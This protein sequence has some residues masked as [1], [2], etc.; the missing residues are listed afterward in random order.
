MIGR[1]NIIKVIIVL[2]MIFVMKLSPL[3][4]VV[5]CYAEESSGFENWIKTDYNAQNGLPTGEA[6]TILQTQDGFIWIGSYGGLVRYDGKNFKNFSMQKDALE[7]SSIR[8]LYEGSDGTLYIGTN[9]MGVYLY[10]DG[11]FTQASYAGEGDDFYSVRSFTEASDGTIYAGTTSGL[12]RLQE[13]DGRVML[14]AVSGTGG[15]IIYDLGCDRNNVLWACSDNGR[16]ILVRDDKLLAET[17]ASLWMKDNCYSV[18]I[19][20]DGFIYLGSSKNEVVRLQMKEDN[21]E[22]ASFSSVCISTASLHTVNNMYEDAEGNIWVLADNGIG[23]IRSGQMDRDGADTTLELPSVMQ[24]MYSVCSMIEDY[25]GNLWTASTKSGVTYFSHG[26]FTNFNKA[27]GLENVAINAIEQY[28]GY[29]YI[30]TDYGLV[31]LNRDC[32]PVVNALTVEL[33]SK[34]VRHIACSRDGTLWLSLYGDGLIEYHP[35]QNSYQ[36]YTTKSG[37]MSNQVRMTLP[38]SDGS[39]AIAESSGIDIMKAGKVVCS[40]DEEQLPY[41]FILCMFEAEDGTLVAGS[42]GMGIYTIKDSEVKQ[43]YQ[44]NGLESGVVLRLAPDAEADGVWVSAGNTL[45]FWDEDSF[46]KMPF[47]DGAGSILDIQVVED[48]LWL[49]KSNGPLVVDKDGLLEGSY[50]VRE[51]SREYGLT[52]NLVANSWNYRAEDGS[53]WLC[54]NNGISVIHTQDLPMN[55]K[56]PKGMVTQLIVDDKVIS[57]DDEVTVPASAKRITLDLAVMSYT[58]G[59]KNVE[60]YLDGFDDKKLHCNISELSSISYTNL[61]GGDYIFYMTVYNE[62]GVK[63]TSCRINIHKAYHFWELGWVKLLLVLVLILLI[64]FVFQLLYR[65]KIKSLKKRQ[66]EYR[67]IIEQSLHT[68]AN[69]I[70]AKDKDTNGHSCRVAIYSKEL[71]RRLKL[72]EEEQE[73]VYYMALLHDIGKIGIPDSILKKSGKLTAEEWEV[74]KSHPVIGGEILKEFTAIDGIADGAKYHH[75]FYNGKG[76]CEGLRGEEI[77]LKARIIAVADAFDAMCSRRY[78]HDGTTIEHAREEI[79]RCSGEQFDAE[80]ARCML[81]MIDDGFMDDKMAER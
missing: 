55:G 64:A 10:R 71:A 56:A 75:E 3:P 6:N 67:S 70:D 14:S 41:P 34:R 36:I 65:V 79:D 66:A 63:G 21:Y 1:Y 31:I 13:E 23:C 5:C 46:H 29:S 40:Y 77:P 58:L 60:Y 25:E 44:E 4:M 12:A 52:G 39:I 61:S 19:G 7:S 74:V 48:K 68:F 16:I 76:Y 9:D 72:S 35:G 45:Y 18:L 50:G 37:L 59:D 54:T 26:K 28:D 49:M 42:D 27:A 69:T 38:M 51:L 24:E 53:L 47:Y 17:D 73:N 8:T 15:N 43:Y 81:E 62:D 78:Y 11:T 33:A 22:T 30:G 20:S 80:V 57:A 2:S 32:E